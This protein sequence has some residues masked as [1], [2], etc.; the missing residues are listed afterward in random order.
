[1]RKHD[2]VT[3]LLSEIELYCIANKLHGISAAVSAAVSVAVL[4][5]N[6][7]ESPENIIYISEYIDMKYLNDCEN[8]VR[9]FA[10]NIEGM[11]LKD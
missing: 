4:D 5:L 1:M 2:W 10:G 11:L 3:G 6:K 9:T 8:I 7:M